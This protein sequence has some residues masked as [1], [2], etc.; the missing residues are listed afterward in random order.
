L[1]TATRVT[2]SVARRASRQACAIR[3]LTSSSGSTIARCY[4]GGVTK[5]HIPLPRLWLV[6]DARNDAV[7]A[8]ALRR[9]PRGSGFIFRHYHLPATERR[10]RFDALARIA[11]VRGHVIVLSGE[12]RLARRWGAD[13]AYGTARQLARGPACARLVTVHSLREI[14]RAGRADAV[15]LSPVYATRSHPKARTLGA[16]LFRMLAATAAQSV[17]ALGGIDRHR[18]RRLGAYAWAAIDGL[19]NWRR[20]AF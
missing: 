13:G 4:S 1:L 19:A 10:A 16:V 8:A 12:A 18:A 17:V 11:R 15:L 3:D 20:N 2:S 9:L 7:L 14:A 5:R 6:S